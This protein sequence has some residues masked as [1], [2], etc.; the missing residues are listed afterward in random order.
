MVGFE[1]V[2]NHVGISVRCDA[3][4]CVDCDVGLYVGYLVRFEAGACVALFVGD[5]AGFEVGDE[6]D[7]MSK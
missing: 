5:G 2:G 4:V 3:S 7:S 6:L 1:P